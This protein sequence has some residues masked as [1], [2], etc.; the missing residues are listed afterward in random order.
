MNTIQS[1][2]SI[3][4]FSDKPVEKEILMKVVESATRASNTGNMQAYAVVVTTEQDIL[5]Q[6]APCHYN[7]PAAKAPVQLTF[8]ADFNRFSKWCEQRNASPGYDNF[9]SFLVSYGDAL[10]A[11]QNAAL[12][13][14]EFGLGVCYLGTVLYNAKKIIEILNLPKGVVPVATL[15]LGYP[16]EQPP[17]TSRL[18]LEGVLHWE[19]YQEYSP[20][21]IDRVYEDLESS[22]QTMRLLE[23]NQKETLAQIFTDNRYPRELNESVSVQLKEV[24]RDQGFWNL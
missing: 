22:E 4:K 2:R 13:A 8:C 19:K 5:R 1:H 16:D 10:L 17:L 21:A 18:P 9:L 23:I 7:Q 14:E 6:L 3:R 11:S 15:V 24:L 20:E 12:Q